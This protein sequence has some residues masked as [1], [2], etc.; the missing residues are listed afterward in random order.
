MA[1]PTEKSGSESNAARDSSSKPNEAP[2]SSFSPPY[3]KHRDA[4]IFGSV[5]LVI[6]L[7][8]MSAYF[9]ARGTSATL[10]DFI[11]K[12]LGTIGTLFSWP[13]VQ[14][15]CDFFLRQNER[16]FS[17]LGRPLRFS[18]TKQEINVSKGEKTAKITAKVR[19]TSGTN[20]VHFLLEK[21]DGDWAVTSAVLEHENG[22]YEMLHPD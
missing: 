17:H 8:L 20:Y 11:K 18:L 7:I 5:V 22:R 10:P 19:G 2:V 12:P 14:K 21:K 16:R 6:F 3:P 4:V 15:K 13:D 1:S 9:F